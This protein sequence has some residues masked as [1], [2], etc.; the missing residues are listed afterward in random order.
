MDGARESEVPAFGLRYAEIKS[1]AVGYSD[2]RKPRVGRMNGSESKQERRRLTAKIRQLIHQFEVFQLTQGG[3]Q[4]RNPAT[5][6]KAFKA[7][8]ITKLAAH[9]FMLEGG[10]EEANGPPPSNGDPKAS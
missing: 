7:W 10:N 5:E 3:V 1:Y 9:E 4:S 2:N 8:V 6:S